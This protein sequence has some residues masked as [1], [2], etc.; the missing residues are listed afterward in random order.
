MY[1]CIDVKD[2]SGRQQ[3]VNNLRVQFPRHFWFLFMS[4]SMFSFFVLLM[5]W[6]LEFTFKM[7]P[8]P[9]LRG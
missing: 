2:K 1:G 7:Y 3:N 5:L 8:H 4:W 6:T 9:R